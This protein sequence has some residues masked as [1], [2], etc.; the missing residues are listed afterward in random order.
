MKR[1]ALLLEKPFLCYFKN[2]MKSDEKASQPVF[3]E[4]RAAKYA[5]SLG[6]AC[7]NEQQ[8]R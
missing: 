6:F 1:K 5:N 8:V 7:G 2:M 4:K 3:A